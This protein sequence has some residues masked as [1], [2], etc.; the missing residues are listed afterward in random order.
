MFFLYSDLD[1]YFIFQFF[2][3]GSWSLRRPSGAWVSAVRGVRGPA[4]AIRS[5]LFRKV[6]VI[7]RILNVH[8]VHGVH[9]WVSRDSRGGSGPHRSRGLGFTLRVGFAEPGIHVVCGV[10]KPRGV[11]GMYGSQGRGVRGVRGAC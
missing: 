5:A 7:R 11:R 1:F 3:F 2:L 10:R 8:E 4:D 6:R 9:P